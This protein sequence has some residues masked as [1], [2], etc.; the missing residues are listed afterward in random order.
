MDGA[1]VLR[2]LRAKDPDID[3][4]VLPMLIN[5]LAALPDEVVLVLDDF[6][7]PP[8]CRC[9]SATRCSARRCKDR[10]RRAS[11]RPS[12][13]WAASGEPSGIFWEAPGVYTTAVGYAGGFT[14]NPT[15]EEVCGGRTGHAEVVLVAFDTAA[16]Q[17]RGDAEAVLGGPRPDA[18]HAPGQ[19]RRHASTAR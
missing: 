10:S 2:A 5:A 15:Y 6:H 3:G 13:A 1:D 19:R 17:L 18:G 4:T 12:S 7:L 9:P 14:P 16:D 11:S 8:R